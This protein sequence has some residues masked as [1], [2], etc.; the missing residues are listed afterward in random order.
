MEVGPEGAVHDQLLPGDD[1]RDLDVDS[2][3][4][5]RMPGEDAAKEEQQAAAV[6]EPDMTDSEAKLAIAAPRLPS[7][8]V[9]HK[10]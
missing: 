3:D 6:A 10:V 7:P 1:I 4:D 8:G 9:A 5:A 2:D